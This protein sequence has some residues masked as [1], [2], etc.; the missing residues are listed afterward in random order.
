[1]RKQISKSQKAI[2][3]VS[4]VE[5]ETARRIEEISVRENLTYA[6]ILRRALEMYLGKGS[7]QRGNVERDRGKD[8]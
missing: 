2:R 7:P 3:V 5:S 1:M 4:Y 8:E 6:E